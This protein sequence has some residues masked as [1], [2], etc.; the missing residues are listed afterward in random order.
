MT[1]HKLYIRADASANMG[2]GHVMRCI[3]LGQ[4]FKKQG[5]MVYFISNCKNEKLKSCIH[6]EGFILHNI[7]RIHPAPGDIKETLGLMDCNTSIKNQKFWLVLDG[8]HFDSDYQKTIQQKGFKLLVVDDYIHQPFYH[9]DILLNQ[10][11]GAGYYRDKTDSGTIILAGKKYVMLRN[12]FLQTRRAKTIQK[13]IKKIL[14][15]LGG[16]DPENVTLKCIKAINRINNTNFTVKIV[17]GPSNINKKS[18]ESECKYKNNLHLIQNADMPDLMQWADIAITAGG[19][20]CWELCYIGVPFMVIITAE[21]QAKLAL[22][23]EKTGAA[24]NLGWFSN[25]TSHTIANTVQS[26]IDY[27]KK[28]SKMSV[29]GKELI[30]GKGSLRI[31]QKMDLG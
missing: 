22:N 10:N 27:S 24:I 19:T 14:I 30:D 21:N 28:R 18:L 25:I 31:L 12:E 16:S 23:L 15:T 11:I 6:S 26:M 1:A 17:I 5:G 9:A 2:T 13:N 20:T 4:A 29:C 3:A 7:T 8:Y